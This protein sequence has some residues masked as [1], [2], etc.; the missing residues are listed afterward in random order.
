MN[1]STELIKNTTRM[2]NMF[3]H[4]LLNTIKEK[5]KDWNLKKL[6]QTEKEK[7]SNLISSHKTQTKQWHIKRSYKLSSSHLSSHLPVICRTL[8]HRASAKWI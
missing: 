2:L 3:K 5:V 4:K 1:Y 7:C 6:Q 8:A